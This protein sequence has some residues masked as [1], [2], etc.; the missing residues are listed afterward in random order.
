M[1]EKNDYY[2]EVTEYGSPITILQGPKT[3]EAIKKAAKLTAHYSDAKEKK[4][5]VKY[6]KEKLIKSLSI[7][8]ISNNEIKKLRIS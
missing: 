7:V 6:G 1:K 2:F 4:I 5:L 3:K 8:S